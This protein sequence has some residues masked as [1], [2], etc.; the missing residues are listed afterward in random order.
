M[1]DRIQ[2][3]QNSAARSI[4]RNEKFDHI[5]PVMKELHVF[6]LTNVSFTRYFLL[7][8]RL[9]SHAPSY[10]GDILQPLKSTM[11]LPS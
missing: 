3:V 10:I 7:L 11:N 5:T 9:N 8:I 2:K 6:P 1:I 4:T